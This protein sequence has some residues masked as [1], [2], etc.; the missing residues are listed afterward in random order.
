MS[1]TNRNI[2]CNNIAVMMYAA[3][4]YGAE[5]HRKYFVTHIAPYSSDNP[6]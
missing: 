4:K 1:D 5:V 2:N 6:R 3:E